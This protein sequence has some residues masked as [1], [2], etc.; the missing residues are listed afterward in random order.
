MEAISHKNCHMGRFGNKPMISSLPEKVSNQ[1]YRLLRI[2]EDDA[3]DGD[4]RIFDRKEDNGD[5]LILLH[6]IN[7]IPIV[8]H[9]R[10]I[11]FDISDEDNVFIAASSF[12]HTEEYNP[13]VKLAGSL[14]VPDDTIV[15]K[16]YEGTVIRVFKG[17]EKWHMATHK[18]IN[19]RRSRW[20]GP[21]FGDIFDELWQPDDHPYD[22]YL[23]ETGCYVFLISHPENRLVSVITEPTLRLIGK[24]SCGS[25]HF[26][27][28]VSLKTDHPNVIKQTS[29][30]FSSGLDLFEKARNID[31][32]ECTGLLLTRYCED[33]LKLS[34][35]K[36]VPEEYSSRRSLRGN[37]PNFRLRYLEHK[38]DNTDSLEKFKELFTEKKKYFEQIEKDYDELPNYLAK[39][40]NYKIATK[41]KIPQDEYYITETTK[42]HYRRE[43]SL[44]DNLYERL[45]NSSARQ[46][47]ALIRRMYSGEVFE[48]DQ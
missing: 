20:C 10:G 26:D 23:D 24:F 40:Y 1:I 45:K 30:K 35:L 39:V 37:E 42:R 36:L 22:D 3:M 32:K 33:G 9:V 2:T 11:I 13:T 38:T 15:T 27:H 29:I 34:C 6:Y 31:W 12:P 16:A 25:A 18:K 5:D 46:L 41:A 19:G 21:S 7:M 44:E 43:L 8:Y 4:I 14:E 48:N 47:N 17:A 28:F